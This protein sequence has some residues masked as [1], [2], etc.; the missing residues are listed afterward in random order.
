M[1]ADVVVFD[2]DTMNGPATYTQPKRPPIGVDHVLVN[3]KVVM[4]KGQH[5][6]ILVGEAVKMGGYV[7]EYVPS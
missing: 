2:P 7:S 1:K 4:E 5:T 6:G 3:G